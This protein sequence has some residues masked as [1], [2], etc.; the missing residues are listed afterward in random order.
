MYGHCTT[1]GEILLLSDDKKDVERRPTN[2][3]REIR[4]HIEF[5]LLRDW[6]SNC[7]THHGHKCEGL[8]SKTTSTD[9][10]SLI[11][12]DVERQRL[13]E[14]ELDC[15]YVA[16]SY[17]WGKVPILQTLKANLSELQNDAA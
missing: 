3:G 2:R 8:K 17:V 14:Y 1:R 7:E 4:S 5:S 15:R 10:Y 6:L 13:V 16:L 9:Q 12:I 11:L